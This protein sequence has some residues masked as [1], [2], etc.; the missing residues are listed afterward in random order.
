METKD[1]LLSAADVAKIILRKFIRLAPAYYGMW[2][3]LYCL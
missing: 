3:L 2:A 1:D